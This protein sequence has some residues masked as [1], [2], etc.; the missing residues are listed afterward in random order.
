M[1]FLRSF[2]TVDVKKSTVKGA[3]HVESG[4]VLIDENVPLVATATQQRV[5]RSR[6]Q[7]QKLCASATSIIQRNNRS[8]VLPYSSTFAETTESLA[9]EV[10]VIDDDD[11]LEP[12]LQKEVATLKGNTKSRK[13][14]NVTPSTSSITEG[15]SSANTCE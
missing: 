3:E 1:R 8:N 2:K 7:I 5:T 12:L 10:I 15:S 13:T 14:Q 4:A 9:V 11:D 6:K